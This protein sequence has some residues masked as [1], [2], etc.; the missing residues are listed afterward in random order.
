MW[1]LL[2]RVLHHDR[3]MVRALGAAAVGYLLL[4]ISWGVGYLLLPEGALRG[5]LSGGMPMLTAGVASLAVQL[6]AYN[7]LLPGLLVVLL[8][9]MQVG[10]FSLGYNVPFLNAVL[11]GLWLGS[12]SFAVP[13]PERL[14]PTLALFVQRSGPYEM[15]AFLLAAAALARSARVRQLGFWTGRVVAVP[16]EER[17]ALGPGEYLALALAIVTLAAANLVE[18]WMWMDRLE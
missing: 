16:P 10:R 3:L 9:R 6:L 11:Y 14:A 17:R 18:A 2:V 7:L 15:L 12:N 1:S 13:M 4:Y 8:S 5:K